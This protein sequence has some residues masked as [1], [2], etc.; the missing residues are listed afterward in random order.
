MERFKQALKAAIA[1]S[2]AKISIIESMELE[3]TSADGTSARLLELPPADTAWIDTLLSFLFQIESEHLNNGKPF[4]GTLNIPG[5]GLLKAIANRAENKTSVSLYFPDVGDSFFSKDWTLLNTPQ[6]ATNNDDMLSMSGLSAP[7]VNQ[8]PAHD[9]SGEDAIESGNLNMFA[10]GGN[11]NEELSQKPEQSIP[12]ASQEDASS[13]NEENMFSAGASDMFSMPPED[14]ISNNP[15]EEQ[16]PEEYERADTAGDMFALPSIETNSPHAEQ[17]VEQQVEQHAEQHVKERNQEPAMAIRQPEVSQQTPV[18]NIESEEHKIIFGN[19][20]PKKTIIRDRDFPIDDILKTMVQNNASDIHLTLGQPI[21]FRI[22]GEL[23]RQGQTAISEQMMETLLLPIMPYSN[24]QEFSEIYD[25]DFAYELPGIGRFRVNMFKDNYGVGAVLRQIPAEVLTA[26]QLNLPEAIRKFCGLHK[27][28]VL[29]TG[30][31]GSG[32]ST[33]LA[34]M[35]DL[36]N[37]SRP[38]HILTI[39]DPIEFVHSQQMCL[40]NQREVG[41]HTKSFKRA[42]KAALR[43]DPDIVLIGELRDLE[44][45]HIALETAE[46]GHLVFGTLHTNTAVS[47][48]DR[49]ID[50]FPAD[51]Q[52]QMRTMVASSLKGVVAQ[53]LIKKKGGGRCAAHEILVPNDAVANMIRESKNHMIENHMQTQKQD[54]NMLLNESLIKLVSAN[55]VEVKDA[56]FK[57]LDKGS[58]IDIAKRNQVDISFLNEIE[59]KNKKVS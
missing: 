1:N 20:D 59:G 47:T 46:T 16:N 6:E 7:E 34:A 54:G 29:V 51:Q 19:N 13:P 4:Q 50:Q 28:L 24:K 32:K 33:T 49:I 25:T 27:G 15:T 3:T 12:I 37:K 10:A 55:Q 8:P 11:N 36:I 9:S 43:E 56:Y 48:I 17:Q 26:D 2:A 41:K 31:T 52:S 42:L 57:A 40:V 39:E 21:I 53:T 45:I 44:T 58:F 5:V 18:N 23:V 30:P 38:E 22:D 14:A 35:I